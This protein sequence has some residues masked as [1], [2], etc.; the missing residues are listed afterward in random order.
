MVWFS[1]AFGAQFSRLW[2]EDLRYKKPSNF[3][4]FS[5][6]ILEPFWGPWRGL[7]GGQNGTIF[8]FIF[9]T[10]FGSILDSIWRPILAPKTT[11]EGGRWDNR[12]T[13][14]FIDR[15]NE[16]EAPGPSSTPWKSFPKLLP[17]KLGKW[18]QN[19]DPR[20]SQNHSKMAPKMEPKITTIL[21]CLGALKAS[22][23]EAPKGSQNEPKMTMKNRQNFSIK[24]DRKW[25]SRS[26][27]L[28][29]QKCLKKRLKKMLCTGLF[30][31]IR[32]VPPRVQRRATLL[33]HLLS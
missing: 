30:F 17:K 13:F 33:L 11:S 26:L 10:N 12:R 4:W 23:S 29:L 9:W 25:G 19:H 28:R 24:M 22:S 18:H 27:P 5:N 16:N 14:I 8:E 7:G 20:G 3:L 21:S 31:G 2:G 32:H 15:V 6:A 1:E